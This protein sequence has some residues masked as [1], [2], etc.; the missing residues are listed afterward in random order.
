M[1]TLR[2]SDEE[3]IGKTWSQ[4]RTGIL[5]LFAVSNLHGN[6]GDVVRLTTEIIAKPFQGLSEEASTM[7]SCSAFSCFQIFST[8]EKAARMLPIRV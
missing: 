5:G 2:F 1:P 3:E 8:S 4:C 6:T 7:R